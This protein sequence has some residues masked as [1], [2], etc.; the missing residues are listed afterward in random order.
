MHLLIISDAWAPQ[1]NGVVTVLRALVAELARSN[2]RVTVLH[3]GLF[4]RVS[5]PG[6]RE[7]DIVWNLWRIGREIQAVQP[8]AVHI[9][10]EG[11]LGWAARGWLMR[12]GW[13]FTTAMHTK[14]PEYFALRF[15]LSPSIG[16]GLLRYFHGPSSALIVQTDSQR[17]ELVARGFAHMHVVG[18]GVDLVRFRPLPRSSRAQPRALFVGRVAVEKGLVDFLAAPMRMQKVVAGDGPSRS[19]LQRRYPEVSFRGYLRGED[20]VRAYVDADVLV[21][22]SRTDTFGLVMLEAMACGTPVAAYSVTG[23]RDVVENGISGVLHEDLA[24]AAER[25]LL[26][27]R[28]ACRERAAQFSWEAVSL[29]FIELQVAAQRTFGDVRSA[30][31]AAGRRL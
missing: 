5:L 7:I 21:F 25:A 9:A 23:P 8:D 29:R 20:L 31:A 14:F 6:Y 1:T 3:P 12:R 17:R 18:G 16:Y 26:L 19:E 13:R 28:N 24:L 2:V 22:P 10:T 15:G 11:P 4:R 27:D 30:R